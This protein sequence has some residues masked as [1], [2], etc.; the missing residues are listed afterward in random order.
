MKAVYPS[1][2]YLTFTRDAFVKRS[3][4]V[5][6]IT[7]PWRIRLIAREIPYWAK[8]L[9]EADAIAKGKSKGFQLC[10]FVMPSL[11]SM[12]YF[13]ISH[14]YVMR[15]LVAEDQIEIIYDFDSE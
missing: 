10:M 8:S 2:S 9:A 12:H 14:G 6:V 1:R 3:R 15:F 7:S 4:H 5:T 11:M 13:A